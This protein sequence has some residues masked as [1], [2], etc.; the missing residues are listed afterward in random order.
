MLSLNTWWKYFICFDVTFDSPAEKW[1]SSKCV[2]LYVLNA[3]EKCKYEQERRT[4]C[5]KWHKSML[6]YFTY[7]SISTDWYLNSL[8]W[9]T[10]NSVQ[11]SF[12]CLMI[13]P[14]H[15]QLF[16]LAAVFCTC[17]T[18]S[19]VCIHDKLLMHMET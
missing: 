6:T 15:K 2:R 10:G 12:N 11:E 3:R 1:P 9:F 8:G 13:H 18:N 19:S 4:G 17:M 7:K 5:V 16:P 14:F